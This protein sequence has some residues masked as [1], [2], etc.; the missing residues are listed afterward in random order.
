MI[1]HLTGCEHA[2]EPPPDVEPWRLGE[3][4]M[5]Q[6]PESVDAWPE[7]TRWRKFTAK[8]KLW[9]RRVTLDLWRWWP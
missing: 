2:E 3:T 8:T 9:Y 4:Y 1:L 6:E 7:P 5:Y